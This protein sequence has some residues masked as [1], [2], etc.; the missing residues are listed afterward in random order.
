MPLEHGPDQLHL[1]GT[2]DN[3]YRMTNFNQWIYSL[4]RPRLGHRVVEIGCGVG[5]FTEL[6]AREGR[7]VFA[8]DIEP[9]YLK[10]VEEK[11]SGDNHVRVMPY[12]LAQPPHERMEPGTADSTVCMNVLEHL[13]DD[14][15]AYRH[16]VSLLKPGGRSILLV[17]AFQWLFGTMD[18]TYRHF[19]RYHKKPLETLGRKAGLEIEKTFYVNMAGIPGWWFTGRV[20]RKK[21]LPGRS[22]ELY[23]ALVPVFKRVEKLTGPPIGL[24][25]ISI[26]RKPE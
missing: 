23:H 9:E 15:E 24:S 7:E 21:V 4:I 25:L 12:D 2:L 26:G 16:I 3:I 8:T 11:F 6:L 19:R 5:A 22:L 20:L 18:E 1:E 13:E 17:P 10:R 14:L